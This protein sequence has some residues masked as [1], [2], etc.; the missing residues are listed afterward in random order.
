MTNQLTMRRAR[1]DE[2]GRVMEI[3][4]DGKRAIALL[5]IEQWQFGYPNLEGIT[6]DIANGFCYVAED[7]EGALLGTLALCGGPDPEYSQ[8][9][10][11]WLTHRADDGT[12]PYLAIHRCASAAEAAHRG[13]A[14][15]MF[16]QAEAI[17]R[18]Q[19]GLSLRID[20]HPKNIRM[21]SFLPKLGYGE[22]GG[23]ELKTK[24]NGETDLYRIAYEKLI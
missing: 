24:H 11:P 2:A 13:V 16:T 23:F 3:I 21:R 7:A 10:L 1:P 17:A 18:E 5:G 8:A 22:I 15:F 14:T 19:G 20:T 9:D 12:V 6:Q 4:D